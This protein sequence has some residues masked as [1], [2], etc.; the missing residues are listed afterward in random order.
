LLGEGHASPEVGKEGREILHKLGLPDAGG[1]QGVMLTVTYAPGQ[2]SLPHLHPGSVFAYVLEGEVESQMEGEQ[3]ER[4]KAGQ[5]WYES[6]KHP[7][8]TSRN[9]SDTQPAKLLVWMVIGEGEPVAQ[10]YK[11]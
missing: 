8:V 7:H 5:S 10:P 4:Y 2:A 1:K 6:P 11:K 9:V 3:P